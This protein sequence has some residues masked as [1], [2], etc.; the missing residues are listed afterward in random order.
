VHDRGGQRFII[1]AGA[2]FGA[3]HALNLMMKRPWDF[4]KVI[5]MSGL[6]DIKSHLD[7]FYNDDV[8]F[9][10]PV[11]FL[12]GIDDTGTLDAIRRNHIVLTTAEFDPCKEANDSMSHLLHQKNV[13]HTFDM[14]PGVFGHDWSWWR[15]LIRRHVA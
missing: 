5:A 4:G 10:N 7:G 14:Q 13:A 15:D 3:Y 1:G 12:P 6:F 11:D 9:S 2:S 8:Y